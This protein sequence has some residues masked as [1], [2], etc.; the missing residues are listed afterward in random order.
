MVRYSEEAPTNLKRKSSGQ[1]MPRELD[2]ETLLSAVLLAWCRN[3]G[4]PVTTC[5]E[6]M[7]NDEDLAK[8]KEQRNW[9]FHYIALWDLTQRT[10]KQDDK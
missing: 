3:Q 4:L 6:E 1:M 10:E 2:V 5:A 8:S 7:Y 9:L